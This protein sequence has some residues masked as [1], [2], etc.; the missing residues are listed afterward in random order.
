VAQVA[1]LS[2]MNN[3]F[4][5]F[6]KTMVGFLL[7][8]MMIGIV[9]WYIGEIAYTIVIISLSMGI[10]LTCLGIGLLIDF[11]MATWYNYIQ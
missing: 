3:P 11:S 7:F 2:R 8:D 10:G 9:L 1:V 5:P 6:K 4:Q